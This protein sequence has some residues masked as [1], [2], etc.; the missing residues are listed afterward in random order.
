MVSLRIANMSL[1]VT[2][3]MFAVA[4]SEGRLFLMFYTILALFLAG[5]LVGQATKREKSSKVGA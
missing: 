1:V 4:L 2:S 5:Q 3:V